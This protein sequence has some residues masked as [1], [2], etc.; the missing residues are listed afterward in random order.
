[1]SSSLANKDAS[2]EIRDL[3]IQRRNGNENGQRERQREHLKQ[4]NRFHK[5]N[6]NFASA[7]SFFA[8]FFTV[9]ALLRREN[10]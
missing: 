4:K 7:S 10:T 1:M 8:H 3:K 9:L 5:Q 6:N 2:L